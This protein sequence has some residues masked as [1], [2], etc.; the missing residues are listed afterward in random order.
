MVVHQLPHQG[1]GGGVQ[2]GLLTAR[3]RLGRKS[4]RRAVTASELFD[5]RETDTGEVCERALGAKPARACMKNPHFIGF[6]G[7]VLSH[8]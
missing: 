1:V 8:S 3:M 4:P 6:R 2:G 5:I 7:N